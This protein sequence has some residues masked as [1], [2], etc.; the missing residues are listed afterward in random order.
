MLRG[1]SDFGC[2]QLD[3]VF[4]LAMLDR[5]IFLGDFHVVIAEGLLQER[6]NDLAGVVSIATFN[7]G[8][9]ESGV[10]PHPLVDHHFGDVEKLGKTANCKSAFGYGNVCHTTMLRGPGM[11]ATT[12]RIR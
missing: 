12:S 8:T 4:T 10:L 6:G 2:G 9:L 1:S 7:H 5:D 11:L 3:L